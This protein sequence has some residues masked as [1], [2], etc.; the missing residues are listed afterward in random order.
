MYQIAICENEILP[1]KKS[2]EMISNIM[3]HEKLII[4]RDYKIDI[5][6][7]STDLLQTVKNNPSFYQLFLLN[8][9]PDGKKVLEL[10]RTLRELNTKCSIIYISAYVDY[11]FECFDTRPINYL[12][13]PVDFQKLST[14]VRRDYYENYMLKQTTL[15]I[16]KLNKPIK[17]VDLCFAEASQHRV[18]LHLKDGK[19]PWNGTLI[20]IEQYLPPAIFCRCHNSFIV[21]L[22]FIS[23]ITRYKA[24]LKDGEVL[25]ISKRYYTFALEQHINFLKEN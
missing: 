17:W 25:P 1:A 24:T 23:S 16:P 9:G 14:T 10:A 20:T 3:V 11:V 8:I 19:Q 15:E 4:N 2:A 18:L 21:N 5:Y 6:T 7:K 22:S 13:K 12:L